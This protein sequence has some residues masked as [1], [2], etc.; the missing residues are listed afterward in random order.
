[1]SA[2]IPWA[3]AV[4]ILGL[5]LIFRF[6]PEIRQFLDNLESVG[7]KLGARRFPREQEVQT[8]D[9]TREV[10]PREHALTPAGAALSGTASGSAH[11]LADLTMGEAGIIPRLRTEDLIH[12][13]DTPRIMAQDKAIREDLDRLENQADRE[14]VLVRY[15][16]SSQVVRDFDRA[17]IL[18]FGSQISALAALNSA[19]ADGLAEDEI[20]LFYDDAK[21]RY[22]SEYETYPF[23]KWVDF[24]KRAGLVRDSTNGYAITEWGNEFLVHL[25]RSRRQIFK[26]L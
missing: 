14:N 10:A 21:S 24:L 11:A 20:R 1:M 25:A 18:I 5:A 8:Q 26:P 22:P 6:T 23:E 3:A 13:M 2:A 15:L 7:G 4:V 16:A 19:A 17:Y 12:G 9:K